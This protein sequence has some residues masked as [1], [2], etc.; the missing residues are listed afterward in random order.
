MASPGK[1]RCRY[2]AVGLI[3]TALLFVGPTVAWADGE[4]TI[5][6]VRHGQSI[7]NAAGIIDTVRP[8]TGLT[9]EGV[10]QATTVG[11]QLAQEGSYANLF[12]SGEL[13]AIETAGYISDA[14]HN[15]P[16][17]PPL[18]GL[19]EINAGIY[20]GQP[21]N[22]LDGLLYLTTPMA[23]VFGDVLAP[24]PGSP[25]VNGVVFDQRYTAAVDAMYAQ[26]PDPSSGPTD[27]AVSS[28]GG[29]T[30]WTLMNVK[31][32]DFSLLMNELLDK[33]QF[34]PNAGEVVVQGDPQDGWT[35]ISYDGVP[36]PQDPGLPTDLFVDVRNLIEAP[37]FAGYDIYE[38]L[39][40]GN[41]ATIDAAI[42]TGTNGIDTAFAQFPVEVF[43]QVVAALGG[44]I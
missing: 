1:H 43:D 20:E 3:S 4:I 11:D 29:I 12:S 18:D 24:I 17:Q 35:L 40:S 39:L 9:P 21:V 8:G 26:T 32:P 44:S 7:D 6:F 16:V 33:G 38:A 31:N 34:L 36:V 42:Q 5:D 22:S 14:L 15:M 19:D 27:I 2:I 37:Q 30:T 23:W 25:D 28:E 41:S 10:T 13:R